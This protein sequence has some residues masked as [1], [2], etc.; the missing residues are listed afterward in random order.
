MGKNNIIK[1]TCKKCGKESAISD[2]Y[3]N[4]YWTEEFLRDAWCK[5]CVF[6]FVVDKETLMQY[7][8][9]NKRV[10][11]ESLWN[12]CV[13]R[14]RNKLESNEK[15]HRIS[16]LQKKNNVYW[17]KVFSFYYQGMNRAPYHKFIDDLIQHDSNKLENQINEIPSESPGIE[18]DYGK[19]Q[20]SK[21]WCGFYT[22][23]ELAYL[24]DYFKGLQRDF[25]LENSAYLDYAK[26]VCKASLA[27]DKAFSDMFEGKLGAEKKYKDFKDIFDQLSQSAK[28]AEKTRSEHDAVGFGSLGE[29]IKKMESTGFLQKPVTFPKDEVDK[30]LD[31]YRWIISSVGEEF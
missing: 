13:T 10:F 11:I 24:E 20:Y 30:I 7:C 1:K 21:V 4:K 8:N 6:K 9:F 29:I 15:Y 16:D 25:K 27:M 5:K 28:F 12:N 2:F 31:D 14:A 17:T 18:L 23:G 3:I 19:K 22:E 26:K